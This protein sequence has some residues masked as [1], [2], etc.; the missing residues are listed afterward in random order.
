MESRKSR[1]ERK[2]MITVQ[3][4]SDTELNQNRHYEPLT[5]EQKQHNREEAQSRVF[6]L[7]L[8]Y[9]MNGGS[10]NAINSQKI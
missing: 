7:V 6:Q 1:K 9:I 4:A 5:E 2:I 8:E 3:T 10:Q